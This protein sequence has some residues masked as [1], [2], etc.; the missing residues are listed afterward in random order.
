MKRPK[1]T[2]KVNDDV[3]EDLALG[4]KKLAAGEEVEIDRRDLRLLDGYVTEVEADA[5]SAPAKA[6]TKAAAKK[7]KR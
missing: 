2:V 3:P 4:S 5:P 6:A 1:V 7:G